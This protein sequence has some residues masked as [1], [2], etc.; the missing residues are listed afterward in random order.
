M[1]VKKLTAALAEK[2]QA[3]QDK[4]RTWLLSQPPAEIL[5]HTYEYTIRQDILIALE[6]HDLTAAQAETLLASSAP[7]ADIYRDWCKRD[8]PQYMEDIQDTIK[9]RADDLLSLIHI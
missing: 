1:D 8:D 9:A 4:Y 7:L 5:N 3:E 6:D 2:M